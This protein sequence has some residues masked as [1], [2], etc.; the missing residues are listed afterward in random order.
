MLKSRQ[1]FL[2]SNLYRPMDSKTKNFQNCF[3]P[4]LDVNAKVDTLMTP[5][6]G[7]DVNL[8]RQSFC[9]EDSDAI[10]GI[11]LS[12]SQADDVLIWHY[13]KSGVYTVKSG[14]W[15]GC[16]MPE[17]ACSYGREELMS[18]WKFLWRA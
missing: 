8:V 4:V 15:L 3:P 5:S 9:K 17:V 18:W 10:L 11:P 1:G 14:Y 2:Y 7:W 12:A 13:G 6:G 16:S